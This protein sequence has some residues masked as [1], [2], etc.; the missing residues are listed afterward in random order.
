MFKVTRIGLVGAVSMLALSQ[1]A[2]AQEAAPASTATAA[3]V[4]GTQAAGQPVVQGDDIVVTGSRL[5]LSGFSAPTPTT[6]LGKDEINQRAPA[7][8]DDVVSRLPSVRMT[9]GN[10]QSQRLYASGVAPVDLRGLGP[11]RTLTLVDGERFTPTTDSGTV[12]ANIVPVGLIDRIDVVTGG[13]SAAYGSDAVSG[14]VNF[15][16]NRKLNGIRASAQSGISQYGDDSQQAFTFAAGTG[17]AGGRGHILF[18]ADYSHNDGVGTIY[19]RG[20]GRRQ[21]YLVANG[22]NRAPGVPAQSFAT[23]VTYSRQSL[24]G[25]IIS[26]PLAGTGFGQGGTPFAFQYGNVL[27]SLMIGGNNPFANPNGNAR[28]LLPNQRRTALFRLDYDLSDALSLYVE[29]N[30]GYTESSG[31]SGFYQGKA[32]VGVDNA[33]LPAQVRSQMVAR[34]LTTVTVGKLF[35]DYGGTR[36]FKNNRTLR[37]IAGLNGKLFGDFTWDSHVQYGETR[38]YLHVKD[39]VIA[40]FLAAADAVVGSD[41]TPRCAPLSTNPNLTSANIGLVQPGCV[42]LNIFGPGSS[43]QAAQDYVTGNGGSQQWVNVTRFAADLN[44]RGSPFSTWAGPVQVAFGGEYRRDTV[45]ADANA[46]ARATVFNAANYSRYSGSVSVGEGY[47]EIN[48]PLAKNLPFAKSLSI[49]GAVRAT[50]Y[51]TS[52][53]VATWKAGATW[54]PVDG[55]LLRA[56]RSRDIRAPSLNDLYLVTGGGGIANITNPFNGVNG[57]LN[58][59]SSGNPDLDPERADTTTIGIALEPKWPWARGF[60]ASLDYYDIEINDAISTVGATDVILRCYQGQTQYCNAITFDNSD[61]GIGIVRTQP[62]NVAS[63]L[64]RGLEGA[65]N[66]HTRLGGIGA[67]DLRAMVTRTI[68]LRTNDQKTVVDRAGALQSGG[69]PKWSGTTDVSFSSGEFV[70]TLSSRFFSASKFDATLFGPGDPGYDPASGLSINSNRFPAA[71]YFD[72]YAQYSI[73][74]RGSR[75]TFFG[76][77]ENLTNKAPALY[78]ATTIVTGGNPYDL[79]GR[80]FTVGVRFSR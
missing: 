57:H 40:N 19:T 17:F 71:A 43:S 6:I 60:R 48:V 16:L 4:P 74:A 44:M 49:N 32:I 75:M 35:G 79:V 12:D 70:T 50:D 64:N 11:V 2:W 30:Y 18:G 10:G 24:G 8:V 1:P 21:P 72:L 67:L 76:K 62:F 31:A 29:G 5:Q 46:L 41:G 68:H 26:G 47:G 14:V 55:L 52:G 65:V 54:E 36:L 27:S 56:T 39:V 34:G 37:G 42:P 59:K 38:S 51:S 53:W 63:V 73:N 78:A 3:E 7:S 58:A 22:A 28:L 69:V 80:R 9:A 45:D 33:F 15:V 23:D 20:W 77:I 61:F 66:Y 13:A 25:V